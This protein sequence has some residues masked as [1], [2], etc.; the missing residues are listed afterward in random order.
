MKS[1]ARMALVA[2][3]AGL[4][5]FGADEEVDVNPAMAAATAWLALIDAGRYGE[6]WEA[7]S[8][9]FKGST[10][11]LQWE[12]AAQNARG[13]LGAV[14]ARKLRAANYARALPGAP[15]GEYVV[16]QYDTNFSNRPL[17]AETIT[18]SKE[19]DGTWKVSGYFIR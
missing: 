16:I 18:P 6:S 4:P 17:S 15:S 12:V 7:A 8:A 14:N 2:L 5:A 10:T 3:I 11:K 13:P 9:L 1:I 19:K